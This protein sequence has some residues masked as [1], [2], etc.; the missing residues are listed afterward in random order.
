MEEDFYAFERGGYDGHG[1]GGEETGGGGLGDCEVG[2]GVCLRGKCS[3][4]LLADIIALNID[5]VGADR[6]KM[7]DAYP[8]TDSDWMRILSVL[9]PWGWN[10]WSSHT[11][12][13]RLLAV[14][15][16]R[17]RAP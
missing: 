8:E 16:H 2:L 7:E 12:V 9:G 14:L 15:I 6:P 3:D 10:R 1:D 17:H 5:S 11:L 13:S 4:E